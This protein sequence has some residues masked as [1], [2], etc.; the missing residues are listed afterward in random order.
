MRLRAAPG[1][2]RRNARQRYAGDGH[3]RAIRGR[4]TF[5]A[6]GG[7]HFAYLPCLNAEEPGVEMLKKIIGRA[8]AGWAPHL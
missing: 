2:Q 6:A 8:L 5:I 3:T 7:T 1:S 4:E